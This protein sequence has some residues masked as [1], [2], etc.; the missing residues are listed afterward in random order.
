MSTFSPSGSFGKTT[1][2]QK[3]GTNRSLTSYA[4]SFSGIKSCTTCCAKPENYRLIYL[5]SVTGAYAIS[6]PF[7]S[8]TSSW[9]EAELH[10]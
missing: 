7:I 8:I 6:V 1:P 10:V 3:A 5:F 2:R 4:S 9:P